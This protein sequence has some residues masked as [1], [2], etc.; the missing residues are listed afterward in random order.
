MMTLQ[1]ANRIR[2]LSV[3]VV[4]L[5]WAQAAY[6]SLADQAFVQ[7]IARSLPRLAL[8]TTGHG[9][10]V[11]LIIV[12]LLR[13]S[14]ETLRDLG[15]TSRQFGRQLGI[16]T[17]LGFGLFIVH[18][19]LISPVINAILPASSAQG[20]N[21]ALLF[22]NVY[23][24]P[25]WIF[26]AVFKGGLME[27]GARIFGLTRFEK[28]F[29]KSGLVIAAVIGSVVFGIGHL[30]QG[31]DSAI[32]TGIQAVLFIL[33]YLRKRNAL[34]VVAAHAVYDIIGITLAYII[35]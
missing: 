21:L 3:V 18:Q 1:S 8:Y 14:R 10:V 34:E 23:Q 32:G 4:V 22:G 17:L 26:L 27:E 11:L 9:V 19:L 6:F 25:L 33:I 16:G 15:F 29:G 12:G 13:L 35:L 7:E 30:Y 24:Y 31:V 20:V 5:I 2:Y 28:V